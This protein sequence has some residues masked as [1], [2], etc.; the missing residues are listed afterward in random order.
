MS[1]IEPPD[2]PTAAA[3]APHKIGR[4]VVLGEVGTG[5]MGVVLAVYDPDLDRKVALKVLREGAMGGSQ[6]ATRMR[7]EAQAMAKLSHPNVAQVYEVAEAHGRLYLAMEFIAGSTLRAWAAAGPRSWREVLRVYVEAGR[8][9]AAAHA[10]GLL[11]R[12]FKPDNVMIDGGGRVRVLD[13]GLSR[14]DASREPSASGSDV[15]HITAAGS[16]IGTP[17]YMSPEQ[18]RREAADARSDQFGFCVSLWEALQGARPF[19][20][21]TRQEI[22]SNA[23]KGRMSEHPRNSEVPQW[24]SRIV[25]RGLATDPDLRWPTMDALLA[26]LAH[27]PLRARKRRIAAVMGIAGIAGAGYGLAVYQVAQAQVCSGGAEDLLGVWDDTRRDELTRTIEAIDVPYAGRALAATTQ[28]LDA[29]A[30]QWVAAQQGS[31]E[32]HR[33]GQLSSGLFDRRMTCLRQRRAEL[34][35][36]VEVLGQTTRESVANVVD[37]ANGLQPIAACEDDAR[38][39]ADVPLPAEPERASRVEAARERLARGQALERSGRHTEALAGVTAMISEAE[40]LEYLPHLAEVELLAGRLY[41]GTEQVSQ[42]AM[43]LDLALRL[44]LEARTDEIAAEALAVEIFVLGFRERRPLEALARVPLAWS[45]VRRAGN[46]PRLSALLYNNVAAIH[47]E[48]GELSQSVA[49]YEASLALLLKHAPEDSLRWAVVNNLGNVFNAMGQH[50]RART[51]AEDGLL[52]ITTRLDTCHPAA[53]GLHVVLA[54]SEAAGGH[55]TRSIAEYEQAMACIGEEY[56]GYAMVALGEMAE[57]YL[58]T[59]DDTRARS[60]FDRIDALVS[61][62]PEAG[63][64][65]LDSDLVRVDLELR[66]GRFAEAK[67][68]LADL[69]G[70]AEAAMGPE[71]PELFGIH[72]RLALLALLEEDASAIEHI[73]RAARWVDLEVPAKAR[74]LYFFTHA[75]VLHALGRDP[76]AIA[77][78][79]EQALVAYRAAGPGYAVQVTEIADW[80]AARP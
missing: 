15:W 14:A 53:A 52:Q 31:C 72:T 5:A 48:F 71:G 6:G 49:E 26:A 1:A 64:L 9:L 68:R 42:A 17:A 27:D 25:E 7:R 11:H 57:V 44:G 43:H 78:Q 67:Q 22:A 60:C 79:A 55:F 33:R 18:H 66:T 16:L 69:K 19:A 54:A 50:D 2:E 59:G 4:Y 35:A 62:L 41:M 77:A 28:H 37:T 23:N 51:L 38:L 3:A 30:A 40:A 47:S 34:G 12:D 8:G 21:D 36:T 13:F 76:Q 45:L 80:L 32:A 29:F 56:P 10:A 73:E 24:V 63:R 65:P 75:R 74:G 70:R 61:R 20:G 39:L 46:Q 58:R